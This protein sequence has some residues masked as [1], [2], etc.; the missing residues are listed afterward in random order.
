MINP[1]MR[2]AHLFDD[3]AK[4][5]YPFPVFGWH[6]GILQWALRDGD[7]DQVLRGSVH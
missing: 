2:D 4:N 1:A 5:Q 6:Q 7:K 3:L